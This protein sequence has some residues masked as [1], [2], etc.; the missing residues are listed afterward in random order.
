M[1][2]GRSSRRDLHEEKRREGTTQ[3]PTGGS[4]AGRS[5]VS[6]FL[7]FRL[8]VAAQRAEIFLDEGAALGGDLIGAGQVELALSETFKLTPEPVLEIV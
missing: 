1:E 7:E 4:N 2:S 5:R 8:W 3:R 6:A